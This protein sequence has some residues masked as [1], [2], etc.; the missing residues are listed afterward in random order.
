MKYFFY[1]FTIRFRNYDGDDQPTSESI[2]SFAYF[3][4][5]AFS[6]SK[7]KY[8]MRL[9]DDILPIPEVWEKMRKYILE[10]SPDRYLLYYGVNILARGNRVGV[11][12]KYPRCGTW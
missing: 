10:E 12:K 2:Y 5:W 9:D 3:T 6:K 11:M 1:P 8:V 7:Y 4:N